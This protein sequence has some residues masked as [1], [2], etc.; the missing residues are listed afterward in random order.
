MAASGAGVLQ[1]RSVE[2]A[3]N[4]GVRIHCRSCFDDEPG[5][6]VLG[7]E[8]TMEHPLITAVTHSTDEARIT[9]LGVPDQP[10][11]RRPHLQRRWPSANVQRRHDHP[12]RAGVR[13]PRRRHVL[14]RRRATTCATR[15]RGARPAASSELGIERVA[16]DPEMGKVS[17]VGAGMS[18]HPGVAAK[19]FRTLG[20]ER[21]QHRDDLDLADQ[22]LLRRSAPTQVPRRGAR[23]ARARSSSATGTSRPSSPFGRT[24][25]ERRGRHRVAVVGATGAVGTAMLE[26]LRERGFP[27]A[28][29][30]PVR[31]RALRRPRARRRRRGARRSTDDDDRGLR[32]RDLL[33]RRDD[34]A[35]SGRRGS[36]SAGA[37]V[38][39]NSSALAHGPRGPARRLRG[40]PGR[41]STRHRG[42]RSPTPTARRCSSWSRSSRSTTRPGI[43]RL[44]RLH[45]PV[46]LGHRAGGGRGAPGPERAPRSHGV[47]PPAPSVYPAPDRVQ[48]AR[49]R[50]QLRRRRRPHR[51]RAQDDV[52][53]AQDPRRRVDRESASRARAC[54]SSPGTRSRVN[55]R[56]AR[57]AVGRG[58]AASC[59]RAR[60]GSRSSTTRRR[61]PT[62]PR[63]TPP[64][65]TRCSSGASAATRR[66]SAACS[67]WVVADNLRKGAATNAVQIAELLPRAR[68][69]RAGPARPATGRLVAARRSTPRST[70]RATRGRSGDRP[71][72]CER[73]DDAGSYRADGGP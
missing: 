51:R 2:Y 12:E 46:G 68:A 53:D 37:V 10:G 43:E 42:H 13:G 26:T 44:D 36:S 57:A 66:T 67:L 31:L 73:R 27:A 45:L 64:A 5:T 33:G 41:R 6:V 69:L 18:S 61:T 4:H 58:G 9:L 17:I 63:S 3:R 55:V 23:A 65:A 35:A 24:R 30:R 47:A 62:R 70:G 56:D 11:R 28:R 38:V 8:E 25:D 14:H 39:D 49:R 34:L 20:D 15:T 54:R 22:D 32:P 52:R 59:S 48:R 21:H 60:P 7:E 1:L 19:V 71:A 40:Q 72:T 50:R 16:E 29:D